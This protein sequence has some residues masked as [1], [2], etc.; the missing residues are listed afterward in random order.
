MKKY[1]PVFHAIIAAGLFGAG[2]PL[3]KL[4][5]G[6]IQI[7]PILM[8]S[9]LYL[10]CG[11]GLL[12]LC[13]FQNTVKPKKKAGA[14]LSKND[15][16]WLIGAILTGG[17]AAPVVL[18]YSLRVTPAAVSS[19]LLNFESVATTLIA[20][21]MFGESPGKRILTAVGVITVACIILSWN[22]NG[23]WSFSI[24]AIGVLGACGLW[25]LDNNFTRNISTKDPLIIVIIK[26]FSA[27]FLSL[28]LAI[29]T[30][31]PF[32]GPK[33]IFGAM[34][35]GCLSYGMS[36][37]FFIFALRNL[38]AVITGAFSGAAPFI[39]VIISFLLFK[40]PPGILFFIALPIMILG[41]FMILNEKPNADKILPEEIK[42]ESRKKS[43]YRGSI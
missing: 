36:T 43:F 21:F 8:A 39:G 9:F 23:G 16:P 40:E 25:G 6:E 3:S 7:A 42:N 37:I 26:G 35:L 28:I 29:G 14:K 33:S 32:P 22:I 10:G 4:L 17:V 2:A 38:G 20:I 41:A 13:L 11:F 15:I 5:Q 34:V 24:G 19:L 31:S 30:G 12:P 1:H 27:G 18:M